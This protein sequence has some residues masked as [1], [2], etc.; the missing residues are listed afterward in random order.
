MQTLS[1]SSF[2]Q[3]LG[4]AIANSFW[5]VALLWLIT[6]IIN[7]CFRLSSHNRYRVAISA[8][9]A[10]F[11]WFVITLRFYYQQCIKA[12][13]D[14]Q[15]LLQQNT[16]IYQLGMVSDRY[17]ALGYISKAEM[18]LPYL[19]LAYLCL[20]GVLIIRWFKSY[21]YTNWLKQEGLQKANMD[22]RLFVQ[23]M[24][25][26]LGIKQRVK[27]YLSRIVSCPLTIGFL[28]PI[29]LIPIATVSHLTVQ[30]LEAVL[31]HELAHIKRADYLINLLLNI[32]ETIL[33]FN[34]FTRLISQNINKEREHCCDDWVLQFKYNAPMYAEALLRIACLQAAPNIAMK[35]EGKGEGELLWR[36]KRLLN[37][38]QKRFNYSQQMVALVIT[39]CML[40]AIAWL[41]PAN[42][43]KQS[44]QTA[45]SKPKKA[46]VIAPMAVQ[47]NNP[48][49][50]PLALLAKPLKE[51]VQK[52]TQEIAKT[53]L[54]EIVDTSLDEA[55]KALAAVVPTT[56]Q[57]LDKINTTNNFEQVKKDA[58]KEIRKINWTEIQQVSPFIDSTFIT[59][60]VTTALDKSKLT[61]NMDKVKQALDLSK[62]QLLKL[63]QQK[64]QVFIDQS[65]LNEVINNATTW[66]NYNDF[67]KLLDDR[68]KATNS[69]KVNRDK[70]E[71]QRQ[72]E[73]LYQRLLHSNTAPRVQDFSFN[74]SIPDEN[75]CP[76]NTNDNVPA[77]PQDQLANWTY[78]N[79]VYIEKT[80]E[81]TNYDGDDEVDSVYSYAAQ[82]QLQPAQPVVPHAKSFV[83]I[84][85]LSNNSEHVSIIIIK[86]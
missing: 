63:R 18:L 4:Y 30:Q 66:M 78:T 9:L 72:E 29:I 16:V 71:K 42:T 35:A 45:V 47:I 74:Y 39:T 26:R 76:K 56:L 54:Q 64:L 55:G 62:Q 44:V 37:H 65:H 5:Q 24:S 32:I 58:Q 20:L 51:E 22:I 28:K 36:I 80:T 82:P 14:A 43:A 68:K 15:L 52:A 38:Q 84:V 25:A 70:K 60:A 59:N 40:V 23:N 53:D 2:L 77:P 13:A 27:V 7:P 21:R 81:E 75:K 11:A 49:F 31:L 6:L 41:Q 3:A 46:V 57:E 83:H 86:R 69:R 79:P 12:T 19:S 33:F 85:E 48:F 73:I 67:V 34:P 10:G 8:Q 17:N 61:F 50:N 1:Q